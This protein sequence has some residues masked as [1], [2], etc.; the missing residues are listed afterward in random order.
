MMTRDDA[1]KLAEQKLKEL[2]EALDHGRSTVLD[3]YLRA[4]ARLPK[5]SFRNVMLIRSQRP[6][7]THVAG[8][9]MWKTLGRKVMKGEEGIAILAPITRRPQKNESAEQPVPSNADKRPDHDADDVNPAGFRVVYVFDVSQT[10]GKEFSPVSPIYGD[11]DDALSQLERAC[12]QLGIAI[13]ERPLDWGIEGVSCGG[14]IILKEGQDN[15]R[16]FSTLAHELAHELLHDS[17]Q[18][19]EHKLTREQMET[20]AEAISYVICTAH[21]LDA[22]D[23]SRDYIQM[24]R[25]NTEL[26]MQSMRR[27][28]CTAVTILD[29][30]EA[31]RGAKVPT[32]STE[33]ASTMPSGR[34]ELTLAS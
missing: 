23:Q 29:L 6:D 30:M 1:M 31:A 11:C 20:E 33:A 25:G 27:I 15:A 8:F 19:K 12:E 7:A 5:Y 24:Y 4:V 3:D 13:E 14:R 16:R 26:L 32:E 10:E 22:R 2:A 17:S 9:H 21:G 34:I 18:R 28:Q